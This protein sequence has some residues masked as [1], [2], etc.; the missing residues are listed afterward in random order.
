MTG[1]DVLWSGD[2]HTPKRGY[3]GAL[4][5]CAHPTLPAPRLH[6]APRPISTI[7]RAPR[8][9]KGV[10]RLLGAL[11]AFPEGATA[12]QLQPTSGMCMAS[13]CTSL[14]KLA[15]EGRLMRERKR[16][17]TVEGQPVPPLLWVYRLAGESDV[18]VE[19]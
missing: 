9:P 1:Y 13:L 18:W 12:R 10:S 3:L 19:R 11:G 5:T 2:I 17:V 7:P 6:V 15:S 14:S 16:A 4:A 8:Q